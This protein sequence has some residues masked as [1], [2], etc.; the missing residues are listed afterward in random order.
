VSDAVRKADEDFGHTSPFAKVS[1][2]VGIMKKAGS[3]DLIEW[4]V[5]SINDL[6][7]NSMLG[8][9]EVSWDQLTGYRAAGHK[10]TVDLLVYKREMLVHLLDTFAAK[11]PFDATCVAKLRDI[12]MSHASYRAKVEP[13]QETKAA[14]GFVHPDISYRAQWKNPGDCWRA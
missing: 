11:H 5:L 7:R 2:L 9:G 12:F 14:D 4:V 6:W 10:G 1:V 3:A 8:I 13:S